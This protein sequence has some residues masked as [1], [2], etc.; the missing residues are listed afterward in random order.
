MPVLLRTAG[1]YVNY[2]FDSMGELT[3]T[4]GFTPGGATRLAD[5]YG[6][7]YDAAGNLLTKVTSANPANIKAAYTINSLNEISNSVYGGTGAGVGV[8]VSGSL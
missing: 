2:Q 3:N 1:D 7:V 4:A 8:M 5:G 6:Y